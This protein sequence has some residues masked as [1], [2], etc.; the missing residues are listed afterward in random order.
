MNASIAGVLVALVLFA[1]LV[2]VAAFFV[3][4]PFVA[5]FVTATVLVP[6]A[7]LVALPGGFR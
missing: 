4:W 3:G 6:L 7:F 1:A 5:G 2:W